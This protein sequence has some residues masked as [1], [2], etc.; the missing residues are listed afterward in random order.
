MDRRSVEAHRSP[1]AR[2]E[3]MRLL[4]AVLATGLLACSADSARDAGRPAD[5]TRTVSLA[6]ATRD[7]CLQIGGQRPDTSIQIGTPAADV[8]RGRIAL[9]ITYACAIH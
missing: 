9:G 7:G 2:I 4:C 3:V 5:T 6:D 8:W 1:E